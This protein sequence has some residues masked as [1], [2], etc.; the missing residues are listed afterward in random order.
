MVEQLNMFLLCMHQV[1]RLSC[2]LGLVSRHLE[3]SYCS[4]PRSHK[5]AAGMTSYR[6]D[7][8]KHL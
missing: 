4:F 3:E 5:E 8:D 1:R 2:L 6:G 7:S